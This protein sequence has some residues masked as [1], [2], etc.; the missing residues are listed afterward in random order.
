MP[1]DQRKKVV[2][3]AVAIL[4]EERLSQGL[5]MIQLAEKSGLSQSIISLIERGLRSPTMDTMLRLT[6]ALDVP[7]SDVIK[8]AEK[9]AAKSS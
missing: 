2:E 7:L 3:H 5:S 6:E 8:R 9:A 4:R 1:E